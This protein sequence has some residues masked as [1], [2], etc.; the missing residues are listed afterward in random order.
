MGLARAGIGRDPGRHRGIRGRD[1]Q[2]C[3]DGRRRRWCGMRAH[4][5]ALLVIVVA[6]DR[7]FLHAREMVV[8]AVAGLPHRQHQREIGLL[9][10]LEACGDR[11][12]LGERA[13]GMGVGVA[14]LEVDRLALAGG[15]AAL[16]RHIDQLGDRAP[17]GMPGKPPPRRIAASS[18]SCGEMPM[19]TCL[20]GRHLS[21]S[22]S[23]GW[24]SGRPGSRSMRSAR[25]AQREDALAERNLDLAGRSRP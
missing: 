9:L 8:G 21:R 11:G 13:L 23:R 24:R 4:S 2:L 1:L 25:R 14:V 17:A 15:L 6:A 16:E 19:R 10:V 18:V 3:R 12:E 22:C 7:P 20:L 5:A